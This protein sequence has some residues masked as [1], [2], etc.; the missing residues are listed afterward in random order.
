MVS[1]QAK[2]T[3]AERSKFLFNNKLLSDVK[4]IV[5]KRDQYESDSCERSNSGKL[6]R[7]HKFVFSIS[8]AVFFAM[9]YGEMAEAEDTIYLPD[10]EYESLLE[11][12]RFMYSDEVNLTGSNVMEVLYLAKKYIVH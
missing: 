5:Q 11:L 2:A 8:S 12:F 4:F 3:I 10:C 6:I 7:A 1:W 9:F